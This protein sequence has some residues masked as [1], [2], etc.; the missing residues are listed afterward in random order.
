MGVGTRSLAA[1]VAGGAGGGGPYA[2]GT[3]GRGGYALYRGGVGGGG[4]GISGEGAVVSSA[5]AN[6]DLFR[7]DDVIPTP[8]EISSPGGAG[9]ILSLSCLGSYLTVGGG[10]RLSETRDL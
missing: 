4:G 9:D 2:R 7:A 1:A 6:L 5:C 3:A 8:L 10:F